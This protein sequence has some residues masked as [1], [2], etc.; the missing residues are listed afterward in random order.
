ME[1]F[2]CILC[3]NGC[4]VSVEKVGQEYEVKGNKCPKGREFA[5]N[6]IVD[7]RRSVCSTIKTTF[8][9]VPRLPVR[10]NGEV[11][12]E[13]IFNVMAEINSKYLD[14]PVHAGD[15]VIENVGDTGV[16]VIATS[17]LYYLLG[18]E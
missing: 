2:T 15:V 12:L 7:P 9:K 16:N 10:T 6:E 13:A 17:D 18:E 8:E 14:M 3:P 5:I 11:P 1:S 4:S